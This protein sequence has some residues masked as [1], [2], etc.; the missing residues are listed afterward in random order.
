MSVSVRNIIVIDPWN[1]LT[2][3]IREVE[4]LQNW[5]IKEG[6]LYG[7]KRLVFE[8]GMIDTEKQIIPAEC[9]ALLVYKSVSFS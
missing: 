2:L 7:W 9:M 1:L 4:K 5:G 8:W 3:I 6:G